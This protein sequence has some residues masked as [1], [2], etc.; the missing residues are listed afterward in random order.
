MVPQTGAKG[1]KV[2]PLVGRSAEVTQGTYL[3]TEVTEGGKP[4][5]L[6]TGTRIGLTFT[7]GR[8]SANAGCNSMSGP[9]T[10]TGGKLVVGDLAQTDLGC[11]GDGRHQQDE[12]VARFLGESPAYTLSGG[13]LDLETAD[14]RILLGPREDVEP[15][16]PLEGTRWEVTHVTQGPPA[17]AAADP[18][19]SVSAS[20]PLAGAFLVLDGRKVS[21]SDGCKSFNGAA[22]IEGGKITFGPLAMKKKACPGQESVLAVLDGS[23][24]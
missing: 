5:A 18:N 24:N 3:S 21:G 8:L 23:V 2:L 6:V 14:A 20:A 11:P 17:G 16:L 15:D 1:T 7:D 4:R 22:T 13:V 19:A 9:V 10:F 12:F